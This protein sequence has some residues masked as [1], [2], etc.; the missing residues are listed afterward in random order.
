MFWPSED[1]IIEFYAVL[2]AAGLGPAGE[3]RAVSAFMEEGRSADDALR[4]GK[5]ADDNER[6]RHPQVS[7]D[8]PLPDADDLTLA[9]T[10]PAPRDRGLAAWE[11][12][13]AVREEAERR[14]PADAESIA[15][16]AELI[17]SGERRG[18]V[19]ALRS[20]LGYSPRQGAV[21]RFQAIVAGVLL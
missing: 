14:A 19:G 7:I 9:D 10:I 3:E 2:A 4:L 18:A 15:S 21:M 17:A 8:K 20:V 16:A 6:L 1:A 13:E 5:K 11:V 12:M